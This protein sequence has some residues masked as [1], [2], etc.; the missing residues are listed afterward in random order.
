MSVSK[1]EIVFQLHMAVEKVQIQ[2]LSTNK[3]MLYH[4]NTNR[5]RFQEGTSVSERIL[6]F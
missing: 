5:T 3:I 1:K 4:W 2:D 6:T